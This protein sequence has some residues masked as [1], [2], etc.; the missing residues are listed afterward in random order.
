MLI[1]GKVG[2]R[3]ADEPK[4]GELSRKERARQL[5]RAAYL[6]AKEQRANDPRYVAM[7]EAAK[8]YRREAY[9]AAKD[10][11]KATTAAK[12]RVEKEKDAAERVEKR[13]AANEKLKNKVRPASKPQ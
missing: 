10:R 11:M 5:R 7:K 6:R 3:M 1:G 9:Q 12:K 2:W 4:E 13:A 8:R